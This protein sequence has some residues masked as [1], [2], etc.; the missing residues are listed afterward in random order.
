MFMS[1]LT[2]RQSERATAQPSNFAGVVSIRSPLN[3]FRYR[4][5]A[6]HSNPSTK[7]PASQD[8]KFK[9]IR[10][11]L[12]PTAM[13]P[14]TV[15]QLVDACI[16]ITQAI[17]EIGRAARDAQGIPESLQAIFDQLPVLE[18][19]LEAAK[20]RDHRGDLTKEKQQAAKPLLSS[21]QQDLKKMRDLFQEACPEDEQDKT[22]RVWKGVKTYFLGKHSKLRKLLVAVMD[23]L[24]TLEAKEIFV[25]GDKLDELQRLTEELDPEDPGN[26]YTTRGSYSHIF[27]QEGTGTQK[28]DVSSG[29]NSR[30]INATTYTE[31]ST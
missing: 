28:N 17:F 22:R 31:K 26:K 2:S 27:A 19:L 8:P 14:A 16:G 23:K 6:H 5:E 30:H 1:H 21:C 10:T 3:L 4:V 20:D 15:V 18:E 24:R 7:S 13:D 25:I 11:I 12:P 9:I 29:S